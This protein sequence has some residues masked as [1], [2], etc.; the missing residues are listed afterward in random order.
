M[1]ILR[2]IAAAVGAVVLPSALTV[3]LSG[4][5]AVPYNEP[6]PA[7]GVGIVAP[8]PFVWIGPGYY[9]GRYYGSHPHPY[10]HPQYRPN[11]PYP[12]R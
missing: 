11:Y 10:Y 5:I 4:C 9:G 3:L 12:R 2:K 1:R 6:G 8:F 7:V